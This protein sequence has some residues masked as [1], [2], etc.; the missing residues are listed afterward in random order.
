M[1]RINIDLPEHYKSNKEILFKEHID[2][3][4]NFKIFRT[5]KTFTI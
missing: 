3:A 4:K 1:I 2:N 5:S